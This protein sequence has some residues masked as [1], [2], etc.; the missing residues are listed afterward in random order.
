VPTLSPLNR[1]VLERAAAVVVHSGYGW[2]LAR[3]VTDAPVSLVPLYAEPPARP[4]DPVAERKRLGLPAGRFVVASLGF[5]GPPK[6]LEVLVRAAGLLPAAVKERT[7]VLSVGPCPEGLRTQL[8]T[9]ADEVGLAGKVEIRG[10]AP[11]SDFAAYAVAADAC[12]QLRFPSNGETSAALYRAL[13]AGAACVVSDTGS[14]A[15]LPNDVVL[16]VRSPVRDVD[17]LAAAMTRL[18]TEPDL[19]RRLS[20]AAARFTAETCSRAVVAAGYAAAMTNATGI[21]ASRAT[22]GAPRSAA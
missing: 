16:K 8:L 11:L 10:K 14:M 18:A 5:V 15:E 3:K 1:R 2:Q 17:D 22:L 21:L 20:A 7:L 9:L 19:R 6:R 4:L 12:V 13:A